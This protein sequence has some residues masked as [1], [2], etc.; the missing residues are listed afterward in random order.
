MVGNV[1]PSGSAGPAGERGAAGS[2]GAQ[3]PVGIVARWTSY[4]VITFNTTDADISASDNRT[5]AEIAAYM[6][7][8]PSLQVGIDGYMDPNDRNLS[9]RRV[10]AVRDALIIAGVPSHKVM[11]GAFGDQRYSREQRVDVLLRT[12]PVESSQT[13]SAQ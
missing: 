6:T 8:N 12:A 3:G 5:I 4:R 1:G 10:G 11:I 2:T 13:S 9:D 7:K